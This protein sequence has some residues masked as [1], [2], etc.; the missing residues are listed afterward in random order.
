MGWH[1]GLAPGLAWQ[2]GQALP[3]WTPSRHH[4]QPPVRP[5]RSLVPLCRSLQVSP[6]VGQALP[7]WT[8]SRHHHQL[9]VRPRRSLVPACRSSQVSPAVGQALPGLLLQLAQAR[10]SFFFAMCAQNHFKAGTEATKNPSA[11]WPQ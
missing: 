9:P 6:A 10:P 7:R 4:H 1:H 11:P 3:H 8:P 5:R 2:V